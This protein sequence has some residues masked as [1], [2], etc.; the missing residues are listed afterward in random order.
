MTGNGTSLILTT[1]CRLSSRV[2]S[3]LSF[4]FRLRTLDLGLILGKDFQNDQ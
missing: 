2:S 3:S 4:D 1:A